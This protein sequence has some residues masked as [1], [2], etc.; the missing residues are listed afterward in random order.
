ML[1]LIE[2]NLR[3]PILRFRLCL[4]VSEMAVFQLLP[5]PISGT[6]SAI[7]EAMV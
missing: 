2:D 7:T 5:W 1:Y 4:G 6:L 3:I